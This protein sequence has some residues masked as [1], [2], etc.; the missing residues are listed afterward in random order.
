MERRGSRVV[1]PGTAEWLPTRFAA[2]ALAVPAPVHDLCGGCAG[3][4]KPSDPGQGLLEVRDDV[5]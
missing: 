4:R 3:S 5:R 1:R 2:E